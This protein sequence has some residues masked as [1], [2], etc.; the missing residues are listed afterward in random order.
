[1]PDDL[2]VKLDRMA[3]DRSLE[4]RAPYLEPKLAELA[5]ALPP[6]RRTTKR[7]RKVA[8]VEAAATLLPESIRSRRKH[9]FVLPMR[10]WLRDW[11]GAFGRVDRW[12]AE[13]PLPWLDAKALEGFV[14]RALASSRGRPRALFAL[15]LLSEWWNARQVESASR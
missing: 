15:A 6:E 10:E 2:L 11:F 9:G 7:R 1:L 3:M 5:L 13:R 14:T 4:G 8:L 12:I